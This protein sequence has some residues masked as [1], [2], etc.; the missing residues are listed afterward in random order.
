MVI[1]DEGL[2]AVCDRE[3]PRLVGL[4]A[5][6]VGNRQVAEELAQDALVELCRRWPSVDR[7]SAWLTTVA[8]NRSRSWLRR[9]WA[10][11]RAYRRHGPQP[12]RQ[13]A[14]DTA[15]AIA[16]REAVAELPQRQQEAII[17]RFYEGLSVEEAA[18]VMG[19]SQGNVKA[20]SHRALAR[21]GSESTL[22]QEATD[23][24]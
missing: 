19:C 15:S 6:R 18:E 1:L 7:P 14:P 13:E 22:T 11:Q 4:L 2:A 23:H 16:V 10:E 20:L 24:V 3:F 9:R 5:L 12:V 21:L 8:L 17:L